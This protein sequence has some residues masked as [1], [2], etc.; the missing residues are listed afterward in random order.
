[1]MCFF[2]F[3]SGHFFVQISMSVFFPVFCCSSGDEIG[4]AGTAGLSR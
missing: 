3:R 1:M 2:R 4:M